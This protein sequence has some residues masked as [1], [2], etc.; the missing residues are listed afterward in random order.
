MGKGTKHCEIELSLKTA[1]YFRTG[2]RPPIRQFGFPRGARFD[3]SNQR[4]RAR[5]TKLQG[6][7]DKKSVRKIKESAHTITLLPEGSSKPKIYAKRDLAVATKEQKEKF[8][9]TN[10]LDKKKK[11]AIIET[12]PESDST[13]NKA[14]RKKKQK[15]VNPQ[16]TA[17]LEMDNE[18]EGPSVFDLTASSSTEED[19]NKKK[20]E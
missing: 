3:V 9:N 2:S 5:R 20:G 15:K 12:T 13:E 10:E 11:R 8:R 14:E 18:E 19:L 16:F 17:E 1:G 4:E 6:A 7:F